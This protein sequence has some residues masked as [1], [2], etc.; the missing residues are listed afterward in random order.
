MTE[1]S[2]RPGEIYAGHASS[3]SVDP[4][5]DRSFHMLA[6]A[7]AISDAMALTRETTLEV[8]VF[9]YFGLLEVL[10]FDQG[11]QFESQLMESLSEK[12]G[13]QKSQTTPRPLMR[14]PTIIMMLGR[15]IRIPDKLYGHAPPCSNI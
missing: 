9:C 2:D 6:D 10:H 7:L 14:L 8:K 4:R 12:W 1:I 11:A 3:E 15:E 13:V 5:T